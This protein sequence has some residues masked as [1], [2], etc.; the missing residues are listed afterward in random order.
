[1]G[2]F[3]GLLHPIRFLI[4]VKMRKWYYGLAVFL[5]NRIGDLPKLHVVTDMVFKLS[6]RLK[7]NGIYHEMI[8]NVIRVKMGGNDYLIICSPHP[9][10]CFYTDTMCF[11]GS[12]FICYKAL[13]PVISNVS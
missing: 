10:C 4:T 9:F 5:T 8:V 12:D 11:G 7:R 2:E 1:M 6:A 13:I 3:A